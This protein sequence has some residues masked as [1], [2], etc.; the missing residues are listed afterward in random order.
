MPQPRIK[1]LI[2]LDKTTTL[3]L[4]GPARIGKLHMTL[5][6]AVADNSELP[7]VI[8]ITITLTDENVRTMISALELYR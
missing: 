3:E 4:E 6:Q 1:T 8:N 2:E 5:S 7:S